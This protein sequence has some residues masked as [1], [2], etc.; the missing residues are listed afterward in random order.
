MGQTIKVYTDHK[1][2]IQ[3]P[4]GL[5]SDGVYQLRSLLEECGHE[6]VHMHPQILSPMQSQDWNMALA[7]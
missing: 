3:Y 4:L 5:A 1:I 2:L 6:I 7:K